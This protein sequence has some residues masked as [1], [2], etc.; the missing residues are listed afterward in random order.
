[1]LQSRAE[2]NEKELKKK[3]ISTKKVN[4]KTNTPNLC[5]LQ[6]YEDDE[7]GWLVDEK[8]NLK[9]FRLVC[10]HLSASIEFVVD[11]FLQK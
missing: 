11:I 9:L 1:M 10:C 3:Q 6:S 4:L 7:F 8:I 5:I 2:T